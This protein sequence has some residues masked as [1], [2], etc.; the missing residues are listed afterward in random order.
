MVET[1]SII[2][3]RQ[4]SG[5]A[6]TPSS[7]WFWRVRVCVARSG[8]T[9]SGGLSEWHRSSQAGA[10]RTKPV[11]SLLDDERP[12]HL[13]MVVALEPE[14]PHL[15][16]THLVGDRG[17]VTGDIADKEIIAAL[18]DM[19]VVVSMRRRVV[20]LE[21]DGERLVRWRSQTLLVESMGGS[22][23]DRDV[24]VCSAR[25]ARRGRTFVA[26]RERETEKRCHHGEG[27]DPHPAG[28]IS[29]SPPDAG[30]DAIS[31]ASA[32][33]GG[34]DLDQAEPASPMRRSC[35]THQPE[36][37]ASEPA[38]NAGARPRRSGRSRRIGR[39]RA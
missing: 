27:T 24:Q 39:R 23:I 17:L 34:R 29:A 25:V 1:S 12:V 35:V 32:R 26:G 3:T 10:A 22:F 15:K 9:P 11:E 8:V 2:L 16:W 37:K 38:R 33:Q 13:G 31:G 19:D 4:G 20:I 6:G 7:L 5:D 28:V 21:L 18:E 30:P 14:H 36:P